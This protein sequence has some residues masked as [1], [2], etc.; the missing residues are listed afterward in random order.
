M[1]PE[2]FVAAFYKEKQLILSEYLSD[3]TETQVG[4]LIKSMALTVKQREILIKVLGSSLS[5][6]FYTILLGL[7]GSSSIGGIQEAYELSDEK[8]NPISGEIEA[9]AF[10]YFQ[11]KT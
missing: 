8:G 6:V 10:Q 1:T 3:H 11:E 5:D 2:E 4:Q 9:Y 7:D